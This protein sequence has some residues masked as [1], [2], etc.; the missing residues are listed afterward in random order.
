MMHLCQMTQVRKGDSSSQ[1]LLMNHVSSH[2]R[3]RNAARIGAYQIFAS[4]YHNDYRI[5]YIV[6]IK[7]ESIRTTSVNVCI[8]VCMCVC[9][10]SVYVY[11][12]MYVCMHVSINK[13]C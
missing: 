6:G 1:S 4:R 11:V 10:M 9:I 8:Y 7:K 5:G 3:I 2:T 12:C 13:L